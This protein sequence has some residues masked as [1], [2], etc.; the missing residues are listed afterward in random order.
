MANFTFANDDN[1]KPLPGGGKV[2]ANGTNFTFAPNEF[3]R[4]MQEQGWTGPSM[5]DMYGQLSGALQGDVAEPSFLFAREQEQQQAEEQADQGPEQM[6]SVDW[7]FSQAGQAADALAD[8]SG[9]QESRENGDPF[10]VQAGRFIAGLPGQIL[11][12]PFSAAQNFYEAWTGRNIQEAD[13]EA[14]TLGDELDTN[15]RAASGLQGAIDIAGT[16]VGGSGRAI[17]GIANLG[18]AAAGRGG[19]Q[20][21]QGW[22]Q[23]A[24][25]SA[26]GQA[27][28]DVTEEAAEEAASSLISDVRFE[29]FGEGSAQRALE[30]AG[31]GAFGGGVMSGAGLAMNKVADSWGPGSADSD[32]DE[33]APS[34]DP[35]ENAFRN[36]RPDGTDFFMLDRT[37]ETT[38][39]LTAPIMQRY[40]ELGTQSETRNVPGSSSYTVLPGSLDIDLM[41]ADVGVR[42]MEKAFNRSEEDA[43]V[44][45]Q[46]WGKSVDEIRS[47]FDM[48]N[49]D[50]QHGFERAADQF[51]AWLDESS[52]EKNMILSRDPFTK[53]AANVKVKIRRVNSG[54]GVRMNP[55]LSQI[56]GGDI[57][58]DTLRVY[59]QE[60]LVKDAPYPTQLLVSQNTGEGQIPWEYMGITENKTVLKQ[61]QEM[62]VSEL[63]EGWGK[64][65]F[66]LYKNALKGNK[67]KE[68]DPSKPH[69]Y[70]LDSQNDRLSLM[71]VDLYNDYRAN[72]DSLTDE[73]RAQHPE[74]ANIYNMDANRKIAEIMWNIQKLGH[75]QA[76]LDRASERVG[77]RLAELADDAIKDLKNVVALPEAEGDFGRTAGSL[78]HG[79]KYLVQ[80]LEAWDLVGQRWA[81]SE[82]P[83][84]RDHQ[85]LNWMTKQADGFDATLKNL[86]ADSVF[87]KFILWQLNLVEKGKNP[88]KQIEA[89]FKAYVYRSMRSWMGSGIIG[90]GR[91]TADSFRENFCRIYNEFAK[92]FNDAMKQQRYDG[93][94]VIPLTSPTKKQLSQA[95][96]ADLDQAILD[97]F[98]D[99]DMAM[100]FHIPE[101]NK[102]NGV[103]LN[104]FMD[105]VSKNSDSHYNDFLHMVNPEAYN[106]LSSMV[107]GVFMRSKMIEARYDDL[108][109]EIASTM[110]A[111][112]MRGIRLEEDGTMSFP[113]S[114]YAKLNLVVRSIQASVGY[115]A[116]LYY[117]LGSVESFMQSPMAPYFLSTDWKTVKNAMVSYS[118]SYA[119]RNFMEEAKKGNMDAAL[120]W[121]ADASS[122]GTK[123][124]RFLSGSIQANDNRPLLVFSDPTISLEFKE[125]S[126]ERIRT[127]LPGKSEN[128]F[129]LAMNTGNEKLSR[130]ELSNRYKTASLEIKAAEKV[131]P[132]N[133]R[134]LYMELKNAV[135]NGDL[136]KGQVMTALHQ[137]AKDVV[138]K[139]SLMI[140]SSAIVDSAA[141]S[142]NRPDKA[143]TTSNAQLTYSQALYSNG[144]LVTPMIEQLTGTAYG[145]ISEEQA[146]KNPFA[147]CGALF[148]PNF[149]EQIPL[150]DGTY[151]LLTRQRLYATAGID[152]PPS[153]TVHWND[154]CAVMDK[155]PQLATW[156]CPS[157]WESVYTGSS[158]PVLVQKAQGTLLQ[159]VQNRMKNDAGMKKSRALGMIQNRILPKSKLGSIA[160][161]ISVADEGSMDA[162]L[163]NGPH[164]REC[165]EDALIKYSK[166]LYNSLISTEQEFEKNF[167]KMRNDILRGYNADMRAA[168]ARQRAI[169]AAISE[170]YG[171]D[172]V[173]T[174]NAVRDLFQGMVLAKAGIKGKSNFAD[175]VGNVANS[176][177]DESKR[178]ADM[179]I[180]A[181]D[182]DL[183]WFNGLTVERFADMAGIDAAPYESTIETLMNE[184]G[185]SREDAFKAYTN[186]LKTNME[187]EKYE[188]SKDSLLRM[189]VSR[190]DVD[191]VYE[192]YQ[193]GNTPE[194]RRQNARAAFDQSIWKKIADMDAHRDIKKFPMPK[195]D[196]MFQKILDLAEESRHGSRSSYANRQI[197]SF[198][199]HWTAPLYSAIYRR[200]GIVS[201]GE[202]N[203]DEILT[204]SEVLD[205]IYRHHQELQADQE[206]MA[207]IR[208]TTPFAGASV[209]HL[210]YPEDGAAAWASVADMDLESGGNPINSGNDGGSYQGLAAMDR[211]SERRSCK[212]PPRRITVAEYKQDPGMFSY[213]VGEDGKNKNIRSFVEGKED[214]FEFL[215]Y[216][217]RECADGCC[218]NHSHPVIQHNGKPY[219]HIKNILLELVFYASEK[220]VF[221][222]KKKINAFDNIL[223]NIRMSENAASA[224]LNAEEIRSSQDPRSAILAGVRSFRGLM[225]EDINGVMQNDEG[226]KKFGF[227]DDN[228]ITL[229]QFCTPAV[230]IVTPDGYSTISVSSLV[231]EESFRRA[232]NGVDPATITSARVL[233]VSANEVCSK[234]SR[235]IR[236]RFRTD[237]INGTVDDIPAEEMDKAYDQAISDWSGYVYNPDALENLM[238]RM[239]SIGQSFISSTRQITNQLPLQKFLEQAGLQRN[240]LRREN[241]Y[242]VDFDLSDSEL[243]A[244]KSASKFFGKKQFNNPDLPM[245]G[246]TV[247][248]GSYDSEYVRSRTTAGSGQRY[249]DM[250][251][252]IAGLKGIEANKLRSRE[253]KAYLYVGNS[254]K[255]MRKAY[256]EAQFLNAYLVLPESMAS[257]AAA[258]FGDQAVVK[259]EIGDNVVIVPSKDVSG[260]IYDDSLLGFVIVDPTVNED[261]SLY[262]NAPKTFLLDYNPEDYIINFADYGFNL[263]GDSPQVFTPSYR[264]RMSIEEGIIRIPSD[265]LFDRETDIEIVDKS[266]LADLHAQWMSN[267]TG[268]NKIQHP[269]EDQF[270][271]M[272]AKAIDAKISAFFDQLSKVG[273][274]GVKRGVVNSGDVFAFAKAKDA[275]GLYVYV[276]VMMKTSGIPYSLDS[277][278]LDPSNESL[279]SLAFVY[280]G[281]LTLEQYEG[282]KVMHPDTPYKA[283]ST[284]AT[285]DMLENWPEVPY[286]LPLSKDMNLRVEGSYS[287]FTEDSRL[288]DHW[289]KYLRDNLYHASM[290]L[291]HNI[292]LIDEGN[293]KWSVDAAKFEAMGW[294][295][296]EIE[297]CLEFN[298][299]K[300]WIEYVNNKGKRLFADPD[301][302]HA[303]KVVVQNCLKHGLNPMHAFG[304]VTHFRKGS[305][306]WGK[307]N[308]RFDAN[309]IY[310]G[311]IDADLCDLFNAMDPRITYRWDDERLERGIENLNPEEAAMIDVNGDILLRTKDGEL[312]YFRGH[313]MNPRLTSTTTEIG[314]AASSASRSYQQVINSGIING[315]RWGDISDYLDYM[316]IKAGDPGLAVGDGK[317]SKGNLLKAVK[318][319][320]SFRT[321]D[322]QDLYQDIVAERPWGKDRVEHEHKIADEGRNLMDTYVR[323]TEG[324]PDDT[325]IGRNDERVRLLYDRF[326]E[327]FGCTDENC[328]MLVMDNLFK[329]ASGTSF[330]GGRGSYSVPFQE[331]QSFIDNMIYRFKNS[332]EWFIEGGMNFNRSAS[333][334]L[335]P[336]DLRDIVMSWGPVKQK[337][338]TDPRKIRELE[339][340]QVNKS[341]DAIADIA[342]VAKRNS[343]NRLMEFLHQDNGM[344]YENGWLESD[345]YMGDMY[346]DDERFW[347]YFG[348]GD[349][350]AAR[351]Y[352]EGQ[353]LQRQR[354]K[355]YNEQ[356]FESRYERVVASDSPSGYIVQRKPDQSTGAYKIM[357]LMSKITKSMGLM[358]SPL[359]PASATI[360]RVKA[361]GLMKASLWLSRNGVP[362]YDTNL[363]IENQDVVRAAA[364]N[365]SVRKIWAAMNQAQ[366]NGEM[367][368]VLA[369]TQ[370]FEE[371]EATLNRLMNEDG[372]VDKVYNFAGR[373]ASAEGV[374]AGLE[375]ENFINFFAQRLDP[376]VQRW[377]FQED[378]N[379]RTMIERMLEIAPE[380]FMISV[381]TARNDNPDF[382]TAWRARN[383]AQRANLTNLTLPGLMLSNVFEKHTV[384]EFISTTC[385]S[386]FPLYAFNVGGW[387]LQFVAPV[388]SVNYLAVEWANR[389]GKMTNPL[390]GKTIWDFEAMGVDRVQAANSLREAMTMDVLHIGFSMLGGLL[391]ALTGALEPPEDED[392]MGNIDEWTLFG[393][394][395]GEEWWMTDIAGPALAI[396]ATWT[397][398][399]NGNMRLDIIPNWFSQAMFTNPVAKVSDVVA[400]LLNYED[401]YVEQWND[402]IDRYEDALTGEPSLTEVFLSNSATGVLNWATQFITPSVVREF[403]NDVQQW[404]KSYRRVYSED[405]TGLLTEDGYTMETGY[406]DAEVRQVSRKNPVLGLLLDMVL[407][408][409]TSYMAGGSPFAEHAMPRTVYL[410]PDMQFSRQYYSITN[411]DGSEKPEAEKRLIAYEVISL[412]AAYD[413]PEELAKTGFSIDAET[414]MYVSQT[415]WDCCNYESEIYNAW[416]QE[417]GA[418]ANVVGNGD[419]DEGYKRVQEIKQSFFDSRQNWQDLYY[420]LW[421]ESMTRGVTVYNR[422]NT[423]YARDANGEWY[424]TGLRPNALGLFR[425]GPDRVGEANVTMGREED[426]ATR[427]AVTGESTGQRALVP[428]VPDYVEIP[429]F[430]SWAGDGDG[431]GYS[432]S[433]NGTGFD[434]DSTW[435]YGYRG[436]G[437]GYRG[438]SRGGGGGGYSP[439]LYSRVSVPYMSSARTMYGERLYHGDINYLRPDF[440]TKGSREAYKRS[441]I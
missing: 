109:K 391:F 197:D 12:A 128:L 189:R 322:E 298:E 347:A 31:W 206:L 287:G 5:D 33:N 166:F 348:T 46:Q 331:Y 250:L 240:P 242:D 182:L 344:A 213:A 43:Q 288:L 169:Q 439:N 437:G 34:G 42:G 105:F 152:M 408:P 361:G 413:D 319:R 205:A 146:A 338:G 185:L 360:A 74:Y 198:V 303:A 330:N 367:A 52:D 58:G 261:T 317:L 370:S 420:K 129:V 402:E 45:A 235:D 53:K 426:W 433:Y 295:L 65:A 200:A 313:I 143:D 140:P 428:Y 363:M 24:G 382:V 265:G 220:R 381:L 97:V 438:Y 71:M 341:I 162:V 70:G 64:K 275:N 175:T 282:I 253:D 238:Y 165:V 22:V 28:S 312:R 188:L 332:N 112:D 385:I 201:S 76:Q 173:L 430:E 307:L 66:W 398:A 422:Y 416:V 393:F 378:E 72:Y 151:T 418:D 246:L 305:E 194:A 21:M 25:G 308:L 183:D 195:A 225:A 117:G 217:I 218:Q 377:W 89:T 190:A 176:R 396:A 374:F 171:I 318:S 425:S 209:I 365:D 135:D 15:Q 291:P 39:Q 316:M 7:L 336:R 300:A 150:D 138:G 256:Q 350:E 29:Q 284:V 349:P 177:V 269:V 148:D 259:D 311:L 123:L 73:K 263:L 91:M 110:K 342:D 210:R 304:N 384:A 85:M 376:K 38:G 274:D 178:Y 96:R 375:I 102:W 324:D 241:A 424:A 108:C 141:A 144:S 434:G 371:F 204:V 132:V 32:V 302:D 20:V 262:Y 321:L 399:M 401:Q 431:K 400:G 87:D 353:E 351:L 88:V 352:K 157:V 98:G 257:E 411:E 4:N 427:S 405:E 147:I 212:F 277:V 180:L 93:K 368:M 14:R 56:A 343:L 36:I 134:D 410:D 329:L 199:D 403:Y 26:L 380:K 266:E 174:N 388:S 219:S 86:P 397:S 44:F 229:A 27:A 359:L 404:E 77:S 9:F 283:Y 296:D 243:R 192:A 106:L 249:R 107:D 234:I 245:D 276:P 75:V 191:A 203:Y 285:D 372:W 124:H 82:N 255:G 369:Q 394:R 223:R 51:N 130:G 435:G 314:E 139:P 272:D 2:T 62:F 94:W 395:V 354:F 118:L 55:M 392:K 136:P 61:I 145:V 323:L 168:L 233:V 116:A 133:G 119:Y 154:F 357:R 127:H 121:A 63:G 30:A 164:A 260:G 172:D 286:D 49:Q 334:P 184:N 222:N 268:P 379:G 99:S 13:R 113:P 35:Q 390:T 364:R 221:K 214:D 271:K 306:E 244:I 167:N 224:T 193:Q 60:Q 131:S 202:A 57:D 230:E 345:R 281:R 328:S 103:S 299:M 83:Y 297:R 54:N 179:L 231:D 170:G 320:T 208:G 409:N 432:P 278:R 236:A 211:M 50:P 92:M 159:N 387:F 315:W 40:K 101:G 161:G 17:G 155:Y 386:R 340:T 254:L 122:R 441:D 366:V 111:A 327:T 137:L 11:A 429:D 59:R 279:R 293:G 196:E 47:V 100:L 81:T 226:L 280:R 309:L 251:D 80:I 325:P 68:P 104:E 181:L 290:L 258:Q 126:W 389:K 187:S 333:T 373:Y 247:V 406:F 292:F 84:L 267:A 90:D 158:E 356:I 120:D 23:K 37:P 289:T 326:K 16:L 436:Y 232:L 142:S 335:L 252:G 1:D 79:K 125:Q 270:A 8:W 19:K 48:M 149:S 339:M 414:R 3:A 69:W 95:E 415:L 301:V 227:P 6:N 294:T 362:I 153:A 160:V 346:K 228:G 407:H 114:T 18:R 115:D 264:R 239:P 215:A 207:E 186:L 440:Q 216:D 337:Y 417:T 383:M 248:G 358:A 355:K 163:K 67:G 237:I 41:S 419:W 310:R 10:A 423:D 156:L 421:D 412:L 273:D 78:P